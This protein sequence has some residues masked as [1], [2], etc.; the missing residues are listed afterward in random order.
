MSNGEIRI[1]AETVTYAAPVLIVHYVEAHGYLP[2]TEFL[3]AVEM[4]LIE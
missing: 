1:T 2:P 3:N 4:H